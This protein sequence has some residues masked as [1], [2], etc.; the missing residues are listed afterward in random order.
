MNFRATEIKDYGQ[1]LAESRSAGNRRLN[2]V[3]FAIKQKPELAEVEAFQRVDDDVKNASY[4]TQADKM[5]AKMKDLDNKIEALAAEFIEV[6]RSQ[7][8]FDAILSRE[9]LGYQWEG[10]QEANGLT[11][12]GNIREH[13]RMWT[14]K[15]NTLREGERSQWKKNF[16]KKFYGITIPQAEELNPSDYPEVA[17]ILNYRADEVKLDNRQDAEV[18]NEAD[19][20]IRRLVSSSNSKES[21][22]WKRAIV[23]ASIMT[24][25]VFKEDR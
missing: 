7:R 3:E 14:D 17:R 9:F 13:L 12:G 20:I 5:D 19:E 8:H 10:R 16:E 1:H 24:K 25:N 6:K 21:N 2:P 15:K 23:D 11:H 4:W 18:I 22:E